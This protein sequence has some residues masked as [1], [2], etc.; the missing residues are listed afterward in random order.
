LRSE[1]VMQKIGMVKA[2]EFDHPNMSPG[3]P[4]CR[5]ILYQIERQRDEV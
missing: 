3:N 5:D 1:K 2:G 4:L